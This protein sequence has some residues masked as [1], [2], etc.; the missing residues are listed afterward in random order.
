MRRADM[1]GMLK[2]SGLG[3]S[4]FILLVW[5]ASLPWSWQY[6]SV[7][8]S[9]TD[10]DVISF[11]GLHEGCFGLSKYMPAPPPTGSIVATSG[12]ESSWRVEKAESWWPKWKPLYRRSPGSGTIR[13][14]LWIPLLIVA[15]PTALVFRRDRRRIRHCP[16]GY[17]LTGNTSG[18]CP[19]CG[20]KT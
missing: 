13:L 17:D 16:C 20:V 7:Q 5:L 4:S 3:L 1:S 10:S 12:P 19:E 9:P 8:A 15:I 2:S 6:T 11:W 14:P 18:V